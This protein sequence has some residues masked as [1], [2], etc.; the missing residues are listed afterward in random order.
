[1]TTATA[2]RESLSIPL[3]DIAA[4]QV[5]I[6]FG[7]GDLTIHPARP[8]ALVDGQFEGGV[9]ERSF[10]PG[11]IE[12]SPQS[13]GL[14]IVTW[15][16]VR[17]DVGIT[18]EIPIDLRLDTGANRSAIDLDAIPIRQLELHTGA[19]DTTVRLPARGQPLV[20]VECGFASVVLTVPEGMAARIR[21]TM[22]LG[23]VTVD[24]KRFPRSNGEWVSPD[25]ESASDRADITVAGGFGSI[26]VL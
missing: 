10:A 14:P 17:W 15:A 25:Y 24:E 18:T 19:S 21:G 7:G 3:G 2:P 8:G 16:P 5:R 26:R 6:G 4:A 12:L 11:H 23:S 9:K 1:M 13:P 22:G 20:R